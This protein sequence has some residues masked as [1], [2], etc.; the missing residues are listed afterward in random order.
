MFLDVWSE[1]SWIQPISDSEKLDLEFEF[2]N[3]LRPFGTKP[4]AKHMTLDKFSAD[5]CSKGP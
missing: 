2:K 3:V 1:I 4:A 5:G